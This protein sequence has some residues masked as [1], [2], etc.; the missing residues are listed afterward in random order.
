MDSPIETK[1]VF[2]MPKV[3]VQC[4]SKCN[5]DEAFKRVAHVLENDPDLRKLDPGY[6]SQ[7]N[8]STLSGTASGKMF[9][10]DMSVQANGEGSNVEIIVDLPMKL[11]L[12]K[13][14]VEKTLRKKLDQVL[15]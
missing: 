7:F 15:G 10:A 3:K 1:Y 6:A 11:A 9:K 5:A 13:G 8:S 12:V 14:M 2:V 4:Q